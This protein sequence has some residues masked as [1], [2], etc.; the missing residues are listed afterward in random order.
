MKWF[1]TIAF[2]EEQET[3]PGIWEPVVTTR[4]YYGDIKNYNKRFQLADKLNSDTYISNR[5]SVVSD[6][7]LMYNTQKILWITFG[8]AK[9]KV[10][11]VEMQPPRIILT[12]GKE[13]KG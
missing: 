13:Y 9:W 8:T 12:L 7:H 11:S 10:D 3:E 2:S 6:H 1:G 4:R 5:I